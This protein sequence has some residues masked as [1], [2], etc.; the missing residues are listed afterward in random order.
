MVVCSTMGGDQVLEW[1]KTNFEIGYFGKIIYHSQLA[2][3]KNIYI[4]FVKNMPSADV[5]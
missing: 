5:M 2:E 4:A 3:Y 1:G